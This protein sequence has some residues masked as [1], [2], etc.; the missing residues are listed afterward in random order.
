MAMNMGEPLGL[1]D[2]LNAYKRTC[3]DISQDF[4]EL[5]Q[6]SLNNEKDDN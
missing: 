5:T 4:T 2:T 3:S 6:E 1:V